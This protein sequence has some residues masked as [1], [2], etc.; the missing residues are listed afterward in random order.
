[1]RVIGGVVLSHKLIDTKSL[2]SILISTYFDFAHPAQIK[3][4]EKQPNTD[5]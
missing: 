4:D 5:R 1:V 2:P 3:V